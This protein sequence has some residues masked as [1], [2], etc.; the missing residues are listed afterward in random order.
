M[1]KRGNPLVIPLLMRDVTV[2]E[3]SSFEKRQ[4]KSWYGRAGQQ[5]QLMAFFR[6]PEFKVAT[7]LLASISSISRKM[8]S[9]THCIVYREIELLIVWASA[10][11]SHCF[12]CLF[13][14][15][16]IDL[17]TTEDWPV[18]RKLLNVH[19]SCEFLLWQEKMKRDK[20]L[21]SESI[22]LLQVHLRNS[23]HFRKIPRFRRDSDVLKR[24]IDEKKGIIP[25]WLW[26]PWKNRFQTLEL[27]HR[28]RHGRKWTPFVRRS[29]LFSWSRIWWHGSPV[30]SEPDRNPLRFFLSVI[31]THGMKIR[32]KVYDRTIFWWDRRRCYDWKHRQQFD[33]CSVRYQDR[34]DLII[35]LEMGSKSAERSYEKRFC[36]MRIAAS[37]LRHSQLDEYWWNQCSLCVAGI[38]FVIPDENTPCPVSC[39]PTE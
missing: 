21:R 31:E 7:Q 17:M 13:W 12:Q 2:W 38:L 36:K 24:E 18:W 6:I 11:C 8:R 26:C 27:I 1:G 29:N 20:R 25:D 22:L 19:Q 3:V 32:N 5:E 33:P 14:N 37:Q 28:R 15:T 34:N 10:F 16:W 30:C 35:L 39:A 4:W 9:L 23:F